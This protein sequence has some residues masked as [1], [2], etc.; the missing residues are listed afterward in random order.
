[1][2]P[3]FE[4]LLILQRVIAWLIETYHPCNYTFDAQIILRKIIMDNKVRV[5]LFLCGFVTSGLAVADC[6]DS[7]PGQLLNDCIVYEG[8]GSSFPTSDY[9]H[10]DQYQDWLKTQQPEQ[11]NAL[12]KSDTK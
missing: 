10:M 1:M 5:G 11:P 2:Q 12:A 7:M 8:A 6:P 4:C 3:L 9:A